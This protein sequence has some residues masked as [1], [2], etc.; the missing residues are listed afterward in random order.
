MHHY[1]NLLILPYLFLFFCFKFS[2]ANIGTTGATSPQMFPL[3]WKAI[4][5]C[6]LNSPKVVAVICDDASANLK[7]I[8]MHFLM[9]KDNEMNP[10]TNV[11]YQPVNLFTSD[12]RFTCFVS[13]APH[14]MKTALSCPYSSGM[15]HICPYF[16]ITFLIFFMNLENAVYTSCQNFQMNISGR[17]L[18]QK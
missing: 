5:I 9:A 17:S 15:L 2:L 13:D 7:L 16:G 12:K 6:E 4:S 11:I 3:F 14:L 18:T 8:C 1:K 10:D